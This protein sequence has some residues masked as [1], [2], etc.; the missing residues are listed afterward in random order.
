MHCNVLL[1]TKRHATNW[2]SSVSIEDVILVSR[3]ELNGS[4]LFLLF[5]SSRSDHRV[6]HNWFCFLDL[7]L[8]EYVVETEFQISSSNELRQ[9]KEKLFF[10]FVVQLSFLFIESK[11][12]TCLVL[13]KKLTDPSDQNRRNDHCTLQDLHRERVK[14]DWSHRSSFRE[15]TRIRFERGNRSEREEET[16]LERLRSLIRL[17]SFNHLS[18]K[19]SLCV[20]SCSLLMIWSDGWRRKRKVDLNVSFNRTKK[21]RGDDLFLFQEEVSRGINWEVIETSD[22]DIRRN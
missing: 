6:E 13:V 17:V 3:S 14:R 19:R 2:S 11:K 10:L 1:A 8:D 4:V 20:H 15:E 9:V 21:C 16:V 22:T 7:S 12:S 5:Q 18:K